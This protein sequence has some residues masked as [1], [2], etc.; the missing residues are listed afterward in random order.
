[1]LSQNPLTSSSGSRA[2]AASRLRAGWEDEALRRATW[3]HNRQAKG[4]QVAARAGKKGIH[5]GCNGTSG[6]EGWEKGLRRDRYNLLSQQDNTS[7]HL[8]DRLGLGLGV[9]LS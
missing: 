2:E 5:Q 6:G 8:R 3:V 9:G 1:M 7:R 4:G